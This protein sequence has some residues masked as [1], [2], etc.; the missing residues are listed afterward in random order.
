[1]RH[2]TALGNVLGKPIPQGVAQQKRRK[3]GTP[4]KR[5]DADCEKL[6]T[7]FS[8]ANSR[9]ASILVNRNRGPRFRAGVSE[10]PDALAAVGHVNI[11]PRIHDYVGAIRGASLALRS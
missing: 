7:Q 1:M 10:N 6:T 11:A 3:S 2:G 5:C 8:G 4:D 9:T